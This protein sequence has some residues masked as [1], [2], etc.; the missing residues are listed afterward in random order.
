MRFLSGLF[1]THLTFI[2]V[3]SFPRR[4]VSVVRQWPPQK[5]FVFHVWCNIPGGYEKRRGVLA[6][7]RLRLAFLRLHS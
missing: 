1:L 6:K 3:F 7:M 4:L 5:R 2:S